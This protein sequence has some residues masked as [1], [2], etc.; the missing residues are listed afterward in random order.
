MLRRLMGAGLATSLGWAASAAFRSG[1]VVVLMYH[2]INEDAPE[3][4][5]FPGLSVSQFRRQMQWVSKCCTPIWP[6]EILDAAKRPSKMKPPVVITFDDG[7]RDYYDRA[8]PILRELKIP[9]AVF[10]TTDFVDNAGLIWTEALYLAVKTTNRTRVEV[11]WRTGE[12]VSIANADE[13]RAFIVLAKAHLKGVPD[14]DR[15][16]WLSA[17]F[18]R[19]DVPQHESGLQRQML[20]WH[21][22]RASME[23]TR[24]GG[25]SHSHPILSQL[26]EQGMRGEIEMC[27]QRLVV[28]TGVAPTLFAYPN[29]RQADF[30][31]LTKDVLRSCGFTLAF[32]TVPGS[33]MSDADPLALPRQ[34]AGD[35]SP[36]GFAALIARA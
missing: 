11:P 26:S 3:S 19:L 29:G 16:Q 12:I 34:H 28:E 17:L 1:H 30:N 33:I 15:K 20:N 5:L 22:V 6:E 32:S 31:E 13:K 10:L 35:Y 4:V 2:R 14:A 27:R 36:G 18:D 9:A 23:G 8:Y 24:Y 21:E 7:Y 25:H